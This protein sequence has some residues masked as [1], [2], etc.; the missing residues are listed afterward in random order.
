VSLDE[1]MIRKLS[2]EKRAQFL[3]AAL[4]LFVSEGVQN[5]ST[6]VIAKEAGTATGTLFLYFPT[7]QDLINELLLNIAEEQSAYVQTRIEP[8]LSAH[9]TFLTIWNSSIQ[10]F[11][12]NLDAYQYVRQVRDADMVQDSVVQE[13][14]R[15]FDYYYTA[16]QKGFNERS[17]KPYPVEL[18]GGILYQCIVAIMNL[19]RLQPDPAKQQEAIQLGF[20][21][22]WDGIKTGSN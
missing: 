19:I 20:D 9:D 8:S 12:D 2:S 17:I 13:S 1:Y 6:A 21:I 14:N 3:N 11:M 22:F 4:R 5:T 7:K 10:W 15:F 16:I 18:I